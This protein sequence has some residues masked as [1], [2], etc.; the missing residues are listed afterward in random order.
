MI[1]R[2]LVATSVLLLAAFAGGSAA[3][4]LYRYIDAD[5]HVVYSDQPPP[6]TAKDVQPK[7]LPE[8]VIETDPLPF[9]VKEAAE[10]FPV[11]LYTFDCD[12][13]REAQ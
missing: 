5:G 10:R 13:C 9:A 6:P 7:R 11:T 8:N 4:S 1:R 2:L 12:V 3:Q